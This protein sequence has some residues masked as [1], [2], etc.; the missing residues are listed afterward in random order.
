MNNRISKYLN[1]DKLVP[2]EEPANATLDDFMIRRMAATLQTMIHEGIGTKEQLLRKYSNRM[3]SV[4][5]PQ[6][7]PSRTLGGI[8]VVPYRVFRWSRLDEQM[9]REAVHRIINEKIDDSVK[10][11]ECSESWNL[12][13]DSFALA[14]LFVVW[15]MAWG[16]E[17]DKSNR[18]DSVLMIYGAFCN[19]Q[20][21]GE[22]NQTTFSSANAGIITG[23]AMSVMISND[24]L[25]HVSDLA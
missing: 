5:A 13:F 10:Q 1:P 25:T 23:N 11:Q 12:I 16:D 7:C 3:F 22:D 2:S 17:E 24:M 6:Y 19:Q 14:D 4:G 8:V 15:R 20:D 21:T 18:S 9:F